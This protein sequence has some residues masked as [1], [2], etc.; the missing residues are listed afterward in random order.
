MTIKDFQILG[1]KFLVGVIVYIVPLVILAT[2]LWVIHI[3]FKK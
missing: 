3:V 2:G 1:K